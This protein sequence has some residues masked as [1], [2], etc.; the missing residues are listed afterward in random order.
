MW[1]IFE[2]KEVKVFVFKGQVL[3]NQRH[4]GECL[5]IKDVKSTIKDFNNNQIVT[6]TNSKVQNMHLW[7]LVNRGEIY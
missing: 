3:F 1:W 5:N 7:K 4:V 6:L 2:N